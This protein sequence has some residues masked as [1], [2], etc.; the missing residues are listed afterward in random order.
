MKKKLNLGVIGIDH[1]HIF[2]MLDE[3]LKIGCVCEYFWTEGNPL[4]LFEFNKKYPY[5]RRKLNKNEILNDP[6]IDMILISSVPIDRAN[7]SI[8]ALKAGKDVMVDKPGC[9]TLRQLNDLK[10]I[11]KVTKKIWSVNFS[12]RFHVSAVTKAEELVSKGKIG[13]V[14]QTIGTGPH[15]QGNFQRPDWFYDR[16][17]YGGII[18]DIGSHQIH[19][20]LV[21]TNSN[22]VKINHALVENTTKKKQVGFQDFGEINLTGNGGHGYIRIDWFT[23]NAL[24]TW[25]DGRLLILGD[26]G[27]IEIRKYTDLARSH[28][29]N[30][31][32]LANNDEVK[33]IDCANVELPYF[34][35]LIKDVLNRTETACSQEL[36]FLSM[37]LAIKA[38]AQAEKNEKI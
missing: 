26:E 37:E 2:D 10:K 20:F 3:M 4:T 19:Q 14:K 31:L 25:G 36:T 5:I 24:S 17:S 9:T 38:Q 18:T 13:K 34:R 35:K 12:E 21:F 30:H 22:I 33:Y 32:F 15:R 16:D 1:G 6:T 29:G 11:V 27:F 8:D 23:P 7:H 28:R